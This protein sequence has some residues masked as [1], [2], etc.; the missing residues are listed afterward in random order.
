MVSFLGEKAYHGGW[1]GR[2]EKL[3]P[4]LGQQKWGDG[5]WQKKDKRIKSVRLNFDP[6]TSRTLCVI[7]CSMWMEG[8]VKN[9][10]FS[11]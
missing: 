2:Q 4:D 11:G 1:E 8:N 10:R 3:M 6:N 7:R 9:P 5:G